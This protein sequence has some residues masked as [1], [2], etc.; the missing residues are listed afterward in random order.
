MVT[1]EAEKRT[2]QGYIGELS[3]IV[4]IPIYEEA[5]SPSVH[6]RLAV[7][8]EQQPLLY[9]APQAQRAFKSFFRRIK[10]GQKPGFLRFKSRDR[11]GREP[12]RPLP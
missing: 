11:G 10:A 8:L 7:F 12:R 5:L 1:H 2:A 9:K 4:I 3:R 6:D